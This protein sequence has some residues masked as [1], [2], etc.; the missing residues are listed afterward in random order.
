MRKPLSEIRAGDR[1]AL[2]EPEGVGRI[3]KVREAGWMRGPS[4]PCL[5]ILW[6]IVE[7]VHKGQRGHYL[8][9]KSDEVELAGDAAHV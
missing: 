7:G 8:G 4:G 3:T 5:E 1:V 9:D 2:S 6:T